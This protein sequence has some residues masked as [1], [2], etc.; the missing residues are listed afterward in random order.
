MLLWA[1][2]ASP[3]D[4]LHPGDNPL[5]DWRERLLDAC[6]GLARAMPAHPGAPPG[7]A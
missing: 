2:C 7:P 6:G 3:V 1:R 4:V 5:R